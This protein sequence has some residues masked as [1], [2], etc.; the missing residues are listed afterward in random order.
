[1]SIA[2]STAM[3]TARGM[4]TRMIMSICTIMN[5]TTFI[6][7]TMITSTLTSTITLMNSTSIPRIC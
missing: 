5:M 1:M 4:I 3:S 7:I 2:T 6:R